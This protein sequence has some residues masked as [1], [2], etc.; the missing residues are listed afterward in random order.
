MDLWNDDILSEQELAEVMEADHV[1]MACDFD[2]QTYE[3]CMNTAWV[4]GMTLRQADHEAYRITHD[5][6][7]Y[8]P[9]DDE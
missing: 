3:D 8:E 2:S 4:C 5:P 7:E 9:G 6:V 1:L